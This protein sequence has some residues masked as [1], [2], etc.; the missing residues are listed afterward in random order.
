MVGGEGEGK[1]RGSGERGVERRN[2][3]IGC[4]GVMRALLGCFAGM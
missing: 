4:V 3:M 1:V 2:V